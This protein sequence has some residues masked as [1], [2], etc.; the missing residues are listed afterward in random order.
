[1]S[2]VDGPEAVVRARGC[3]AGESR[4]GRDQITVQL[5]ATHQRAVNRQPDARHALLRDGGR[6]LRATPRATVT[7]A[8][9]SGNGRSPRG[10]ARRNGRRSVPGRS[11]F[12][13]PR[14]A[15]YGASATPGPAAAQRRGLL[16]GVRDDGAPRGSP[17]PWT[18]SAFHGS[19]VLSK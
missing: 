15:G 14:R 3:L 2:I 18:S 10:S 7:P 11:G 5:E 1:M 13:A 17:T 12:G 6:P 9:R 4:P 16:R 19:R 8:S